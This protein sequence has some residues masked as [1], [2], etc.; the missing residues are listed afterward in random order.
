MKFQSQIAPQTMFVYLFWQ[1]NIFI[2]NF[3]L[4]FCVNNVFCTQTRLLS[5]WPSW[6]TTSFTI[7]DGCTHKWRDGLRKKTGRLARSYAFFHS[8]TSPVFA[9][10]Y[11][12]YAM[13]RIKN[14]VK[15]W[16]NITTKHTCVLAGKKKRERECVCVCV[17]VCVW[18]SEWE[19]VE[20]I[21]ITIKLLKYYYFGLFLIKII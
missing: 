12:L 8:F 16:K 13:T 18:E 2:S 10:V 15:R 9:F 17:C 7:N 1:K 6:Q 19:S 14:Y 11:A 4:S 5:N 21:D 20:I 3:F